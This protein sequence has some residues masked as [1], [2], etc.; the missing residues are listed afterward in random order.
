VF[1]SSIYIPSLCQVLPR[2]V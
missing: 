2:W 1:I